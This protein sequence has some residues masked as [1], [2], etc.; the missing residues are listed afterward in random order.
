MQEKKPLKKPP[1]YRRRL[2]RDIRDVGCRER[3]LYEVF[4]RAL[5]VTASMDAERHII[6]AIAFA[7]A[8]DIP[9]PKFEHALRKYKRRV[10]LALS[11]ASP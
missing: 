10:T 4:Q 8:L 3:T 2:P 7:H 11:L 5:A 6:L 9:L 1:G